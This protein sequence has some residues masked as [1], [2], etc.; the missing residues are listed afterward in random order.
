MQR[1]K[2]VFLRL[3]EQER[4][5]TSYLYSFTLLNLVILHKSNIV[6]KSSIK[7]NQRYLFTSTA[8]S[9]TLDLHESC[10]ATI[11]GPIEEFKVLFCYFGPMMST[12]QIEPVP[13]NGN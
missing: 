1:E 12:S 9:Q 4:N 3:Q 6:F 11:A 5:S 2:V 7:M 13:K 8:Q 10:T